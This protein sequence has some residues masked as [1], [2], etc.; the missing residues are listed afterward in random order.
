MRS[1]RGTVELLG[2]MEH[3]LRARPRAAVLDEAQMPASHTRLERQLELA[4]PAALPPLPQHRADGRPG[5]SDRHAAI[6]NETDPDIRRAAVETVGAEDA[7]YVD[8]LASVTGHDEISDLIR[9][10]QQQL[11]GHVFRLL[12]GIDAHHNVARFAWELVPA[13]ETP[14]RG[15]D[16]SRPLPPVVSNMC[17]PTS[18][19]APP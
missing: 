5:R 1:R 14:G 7:R 15:A 4:E 9:A 11:P 12:D 3:H 8:P 10:V 6:W 18:L 13:D 16:A 19:P 2:E 17:S